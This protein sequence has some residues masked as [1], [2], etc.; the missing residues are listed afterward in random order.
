[1]HVVES[2]SDQLFYMPWHQSIQA[3]FM[4]ASIAIVLICNVPSGL[5]LAVQALKGELFVEAKEFVEANNR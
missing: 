4:Q 5:L 3:M 2:D 1:M